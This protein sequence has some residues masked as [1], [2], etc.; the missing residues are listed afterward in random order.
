MVTE[1]TSRQ[2]NFRSAGRTNEQF[3]SP[4]AM[5][6]D[7]CTSGKESQY[8]LS[9]VESVFFICSLRDRSLIT[10]RVGLQNGGGGGG[11]SSFRWWAGGF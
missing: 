7:L 2:C 8:K 9:L 5:S 11:V 10:G 3:K 1:G 6:C 4:G